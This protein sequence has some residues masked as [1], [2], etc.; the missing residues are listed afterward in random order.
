M[1]GVPRSVKIM[2]QRFVVGVTKDLKVAVEAETTTDLPGDGEWHHEHEL[3]A[4]NGVCD[5]DSQVI[6]IDAGL[7]DDKTRETFLH[8]NLHAMLSLAGMKGDL[9]GVAEERVIKRLSPIL[10]LY[11]RDNPRVYTFLTGRST[12]R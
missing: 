4:V 1:R 10:L 9:D 6:A 5:S 7:G 12:Y 2:G 11:L 3:R 8:E